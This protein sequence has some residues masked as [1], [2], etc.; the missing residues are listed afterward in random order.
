MQCESLPERLER[1]DG[2]LGLTRAEG[3]ELAIAFADEEQ[4]VGLRCMV[5]PELGSGKLQG[6]LKREQPWPAGQPKPG[7][8]VAATRRVKG[9]HLRWGNGRHDETVSPPKLSVHFERSSG[10]IEDGVDL[11]AP[12]RR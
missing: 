5:A 6:M 2:G 3:F 1:P 4:A 11:D 10:L 12:P 8:G 7:T 9:D